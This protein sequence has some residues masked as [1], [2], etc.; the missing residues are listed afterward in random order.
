MMWDWNEEKT[1]FL[2]WLV[3][4][5]NGGIVPG[6]ER[7][8]PAEYCGLAR[9]VFWPLEPEDSEEAEELVDSGWDR[10]QWG[11]LAVRDEAFVQR[12]KAECDRQGL[13]TAVLALYGGEQ[14]LA[15]EGRVLG[16]ECTSDGDSLA[17]CVWAD[18][19]WDA[20]G[21]N[22]NRLFA[23]AQQALEYGRLRAGGED[24]GEPMA[25]L[26]VRAPS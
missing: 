14:Q 15:P 20:P 12:Y 6:D 3:G 2:G 7:G 24:W 21:L 26:L 23:C 8:M 11:T 10:Y 18:Q 17:S 16:Y 22:A 4:L 5:D 9:Y 13:Q 1:G 25:L 19:A